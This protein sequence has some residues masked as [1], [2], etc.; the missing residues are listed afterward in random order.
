MSNI[1]IKIYKLNRTN[2][3]K[4]YV[5]IF[6]CCVAGVVNWLTMYYNYKTFFIITLYFYGS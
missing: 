3:D 2:T 1:I 6:E 4:Q 5:A